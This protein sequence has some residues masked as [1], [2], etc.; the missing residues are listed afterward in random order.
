MNA[1]LHRRAARATAS[2]RASGADRCAGHAAAALAAAALA[3]CGSGQTGL[4][5]VELTTAPGSTVLDGV[6][7]LRLTVTEPR[8]VAEATRN[9]AGGFD[10][11][12]DV[13]A[14]GLAGS[15]IVEGFDGAGDLVACGQ[16]PPFP[17]AAINARLVV[18]MAP[19]LSI[20]PAPRLLTPRRGDVTGA[21][22]DYGAIFAGGVDADGAPSDAI[23]I[24]N[25]YDHTLVAG[26]P[27]PAPRERLQL[28]IGTN[29]AVFLYGGLDA[30]HDAT[31]TF[32]RFDTTVAPNGAYSNLGEQAGLPRAG[33]TAVPV[34]ANHFLVT[35]TPPLEILNNLVNPRTDVP[36]LPPVAVTV[37]DTERKPVVVFAGPDGVVR[38]RDNRFDVL[39]DRIQRVDHGI[40]A[41][42][43]GRVLVVGGAPKGGPLDAE[44]LLINA[45]TGELTPIATLLATP[46]A[47]PGVAATRRHIVVSGGLDAN[48]APIP[49]AEVFDATTLAPAGVIPALPRIAPFAFALTDDQILIGG[50]IEPSDTL[51]LFTPPPPPP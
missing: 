4:L 27:M 12:L 29:G 43:G 13:D 28:G 18:Y 25:A 3:A 41:L 22:L 8:T 23:A 20:A 15:L 31:G 50:G 17:V 10:I 39:S 46:R 48:G 47:R 49:D 34:G 11:V 16:S 42:P 19:P 6:A 1:P 36:S 32:L 38:F 45:A 2:A 51:E 5:A 21:A 40:T 24:Y 7:K 14:S 30:N 44:A 35:G 37:I 9:G 33:E 26:K